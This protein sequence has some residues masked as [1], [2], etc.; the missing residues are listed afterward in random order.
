MNCGM[1]VRHV[2]D[3][4]CIHCAKCMDVCAQKAISLKAGKVVLSAPADARREEKAAKNGNSGR[5]ITG[6]MIAVLCLAL[7]WFNFLD[8]AVRAETGTQGVQI[9]TGE[10]S[11]GYDPG[12]EL[13]DFTLTC[14]DGTE[15]HLADTR[16]KVVFINLWATYCGP[17][18]HELPY[19]NDLYKEHGDD[20]AMLAAHSSIVTDDPA[21]FLKDKGWEIPFT[22][23]TDDDLLW[24]IVNGSS[25]LPQTIVL[26]KDGIVVYNQ[27]GSVTPEMLEALYKQAEQGYY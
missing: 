16:G 13:E 18:V 17:C 2:G 9:G 3:H 22:V 11:T 26:D 25:T 8:P 12:M 7:V 14:L 6:A 15:F 27:K 10:V 21:E 1:D 5:I 4:E 19:F 20:I 23:D 24:K